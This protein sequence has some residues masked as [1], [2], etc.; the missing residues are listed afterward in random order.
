MLDKLI[1]LG[2]EKAG[3]WILN[4]GNLKL[5]INKYPEKN[6][7]LYS[8]VVDGKIKYIG[9][10]IR[11]F[12]KRMYGYHKPG[13]TQTTNIEKNDL[14]ITSLKSGK[15][16]EI[17]LWYDR[18]PKKFKDKIEINLAAGLED[19]MILEFNCEW[20]KTVKGR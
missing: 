7:I 6:N 4:D 10:S 2:F 16:V 5:I 3:D 9:K 15:V 14:I 19:N 8:F 18:D 1:A 20:N 17:F 11:T 13:N 12:K